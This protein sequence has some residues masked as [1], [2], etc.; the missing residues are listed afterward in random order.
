VTGDAPPASR[1]PSSPSD[2]KHG[3]DDEASSSDPSAADQGNGGGGPA[4]DGTASGGR[5]RWRD[6]PWVRYAPYLVWGGFVLRVVTVLWVS[7]GWF[8]TDDD[9]DYVTRE[10]WGSTLEPHADHFNVVTSAWALVARGLVGLDY[11]P[12]YAL[13]AAIAWSLVGLAAWYVWRRLDV[14]PLWAAGGAVLLM[15]LGTSAWIQFGHGG[16]GVAA[17]AT[18]AAVYLDERCL[19]TRH[20]VANFLLSLVA[21]FA[22]STAGLAVVVRFGLSVVYRKWNGVVAAGSVALLYVLARFFLASATPRTYATGLR[23]LTDVVTTVRAGL[24]IIGLG[25]QAVIPWPSSFVW[26]LGLLFLGLAVWL[27]V[28]WR[29]SYFSAA[30]IGGAGVYVGISLIVRFLGRPSKLDALLGHNWDSLTG[31]RFANLAL[32]YV[33]VAL[34]PLLASRSIRMKALTWAASGAMALMLV[35][36]FVQSFD[37]YG[38]IEDK[39]E[40]PKKSQHPKASRVAGLVEMRAL[41]EPAYPSGQRGMHPQL[42]KFF[43]LNTVDFIIEKGLVESLLASDIY[44][45]GGVESISETMVRGRL[46]TNV[47]YWG[48]PYGDWGDLDKSPKEDCVVITGHR[49]FPVLAATRFSLER[50]GDHDVTI[51]WVDEYGTGKLTV[52][53]EYWRLGGGS[54]M[55]EVTPP[56]PGAESGR[57]TIESD[58]VLMCFP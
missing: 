24:E 53:N 2:E 37:T 10:G 42:S 15:W 57:I 17:A 6:I 47:H 51:V 25:R 11:W 50:V 32:A 9:W 39:S 23:A 38:Q 8:F 58:E 26:V 14:N 56:E 49:K 30:L 54:V 33:L 18:I 36:G 46:R 52:S 44:R 45:M 13:F 22:S 29:L 4:S 3:P 21:A 31:P 34:V 55:V 41:G 16:Q 19:C 27:L 20:V 12:G 40:H 28:A 43:S 7:R 5:I 48:K 35:F 1:E